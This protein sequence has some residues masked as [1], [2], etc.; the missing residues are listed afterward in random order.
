MDLKIR[1]YLYE[2]NLSK[3]FTIY[4]YFVEKYNCVPSTLKL[5][6]SLERSKANFEAALD[7]IDLPGQQLEL[8]HQQWE[9]AKNK[10]VVDGDYPYYHFYDSKKSKLCMEFTI[11]YGELNV[12]LLYHYLEHGLEDWIFTQLDALRNKFS[13]VVKPVFRV[14]HKSDQRF[15]TKDIAID[16]FD[17]DLAKNYNDDFVEVH[18][19]I[20]DSLSSK[21][22]GLILLHGQPGTGKTSYIKHLMGKY[23]K[24]KFIF[25]PNDFVAELLKPDFISFLITHRDVILII[26]DAEKV[27]LSRDNAGSGSLVANILQLT[28]GL[29]SDY[30]NIKVICTF[31]TDRSKI[32]KALFRKGRMIA[33]YEFKPLARQKAQQLLNLSNGELITEDMTLA[34]IYHYQSNN[35]SEGEKKRIG[36]KQ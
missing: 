33:F 1:K 36:F 10:E 26:E 4:G 28:D 25:I 11:E 21:R 5:E 18:Q 31:N 17:I 24:Q 12:K 6:L 32:D 34:E 14:L 8:V 27:I 19:I 30:L 13:E 29:F 9:I 23:P 22:S 3:H 2:D 16:I 20:E 7:C 35:F 15:S